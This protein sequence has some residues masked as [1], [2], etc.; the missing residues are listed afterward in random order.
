M[1]KLSVNINKSEKSYPI[2]I[3]DKPVSTL[4]DDI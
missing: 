3:N 4:K 2:I 1:I